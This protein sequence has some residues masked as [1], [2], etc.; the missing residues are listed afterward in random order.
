MRL[1]LL[2]SLV[3]AVIGFTGLVAA[4]PAAYA[5]TGNY[6]SVD[7]HVIVSN[8]DPGITEYTTITHG[9]IYSSGKPSCLVFGKGIITWCGIASGNG[10]TM[11]DSGFNYQWTDANN[12]THK[13]WVRLDLYSSRKCNVRGDANSYSGL[14]CQR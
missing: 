9:L 13:F 5:A 12:I 1:R 4:V 2:I 8:S 3:A 14:V 10:T 6:S 11:I 7:A